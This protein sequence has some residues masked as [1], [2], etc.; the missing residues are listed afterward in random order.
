MVVLHGVRHSGVAAESRIAETSGLEERL[1]G[2][3]LR[4]LESRGEVSR[5]NGRRPGW[6]LTPPGRSAHARLLSADVKASGCRRALEK[7]SSRFLS[8]N[9]ELLSV[10]TDRQDVLAP[11]RSGSAPR[12][13]RGGGD[14]SGTGRRERQRLLSRHSSL[15]GEA[16]Q[17][18]GELASQMDLLGPY[19]PR[20]P[21]ARRA[22]ES[23][24]ADWM[25]APWLDSYHTVWFELHED[26]LLTLGRSRQH[27]VAG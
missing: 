17:M 25:A 23:G 4:M 6:A 9:G 14:A 2:A 12:Q 16:V 15:H 11:R 26:L 7:C 24:D 3:K 10:C 22:L 8:L 27:E 19:G 20:L 18:C 5:R 1:V 21:R 13:G